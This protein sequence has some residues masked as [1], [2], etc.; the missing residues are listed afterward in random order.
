MDKIILTDEEYVLLKKLIDNTD[1]KTKES[2]K[3]MCNKYFSKPTNIK[4]DDAHYDGI[5]IN[6]MFVVLIDGEKHEHI[7]KTSL[8]KSNG[9]EI[10]NDS[11]L[12]QAILGKHP[13]ETF[14]YESDGVKHY[15]R[16]VSVEN[17]DF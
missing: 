14:V 10:L 3:N 12:A 13:G 15:C 17:N 16:I 11:P 5:Y 2:L 6:E 7:I 9:D 4:N 1:L 8:N